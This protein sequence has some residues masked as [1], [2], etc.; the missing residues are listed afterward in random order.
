[1]LVISFS[2]ILCGFGTSEEIEEFGQFEAGMA[3]NL[4]GTAQRTEGSRIPDEKTFRD[5]FKV[6]DAGAVHRALGGWLEGVRERREEET[7]GGRAVNID[8]KTIRGSRK[9]GERDTCG[10]GLGRGA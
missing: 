8:G 1:M 10:I 3:G 7:E 6:L 2:A 5:L 9:T 4:S